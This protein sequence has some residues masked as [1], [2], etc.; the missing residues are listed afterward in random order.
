[1]HIRDLEIRTKLGLLVGISAACLLSLALS[2]QLS[3]RKI[4]VNGP[5]YHDIKSNLDLVADILPPPEYIIETYLTTYQLLDETDPVTR[6]TLISKCRS[7]KRDYETRHEFWKGTLPEGVLRH[8]MIDESYAPAQRFFG[9]LEKDFIPAL[10]AGDRAKAA[11]IARGDLKTAY[12]EHRRAIDKVVSQANLESGQIEANTNGAISFA[13]RMAWILM[14]AFL[15]A[16]VAV[17]VAIGRSI[18]G[19]VALLTRLLEEVVRGD[20]DL[21]KRIPISTREEIGRLS[22]L[23][24]QFIAKVHGIVKE[25]SRETHTLSASSEELSATSSQF[26]LGSQ[27]IAQNS[28]IVT[29]SAMEA[30]K[31]MGTIAHSADSMSHGVSTVASAIEQLNASMAEISSSCQSESDIASEAYES[32]KT[33]QDQVAK[34]EHSAQEIGKVVDVINAI[35]NQTKL[36]ALNATIEAAR[37]GEAGKGFSVVAGEVKQLAKQTADATDE[38][39]SH[40]ERMQADTKEAVTAIAGISEV[41]RSVNEVSR[42]IMRSVHEQSGAIGEIARSFSATEAKQIATSVAH[43]AEEMAEI[44]TSISSLEKANREA[45]SGIEQLNQSAAELSRLSSD[46]QSL[47]GQFQI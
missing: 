44:S 6:D 39:R 41:V 12:M 8:A 23:F 29:A 1:M 16:Q 14:G 22:E 35:A 18:T 34:L 4:M 5:I 43:S 40:I 11:S 27:D 45:S 17:A 32:S 26:A 31:G 3:T 46:L 42:S 33:S 21:T 36:L 24:N 30:S 38:I 10:Q 15:A 20:G 13:D 9:I 2:I 28:R 25:I 7:L 37:A 47:V 19:P